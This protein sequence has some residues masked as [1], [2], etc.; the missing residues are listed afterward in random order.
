MKTSAS[1][2]PNLPGGRKT[3]GRYLLLVCKLLHTGLRG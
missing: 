2:I 1:A 3:L